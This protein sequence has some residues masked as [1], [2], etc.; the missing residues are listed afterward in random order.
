MCRK[1]SVREKR[2]AVSRVRYGSNIFSRDRFGNAPENLR[3]KRNAR[4][5]HG[6]VSRVRYDTSEKSVA[7]QRKVWYSVL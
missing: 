4:E 6:T 5:K 7:R 2:G 3:S 1:Q